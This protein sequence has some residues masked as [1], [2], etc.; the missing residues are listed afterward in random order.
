MHLPLRYL[1]QV[2][3]SIARLGIINALAFLL[4]MMAIL[5]WSC[6]LPYLRDQSRQQQASIIDV[7]KSL[8]TPVKPVFSAPQL[9]EH[10]HLKE[11]YEILGETNYAEQQVKTLFSM[12][13]ENGLLLAQ[14]DYLL[15]SDKAGGFD[16]YQ[17]NFPVK[18]SYSSV[19]QFCMKL[20]PSLPFASLD[21][22]HFKRSVIASD[23]VEVRL[24]LTLYLNNGFSR[25]DRHF[26]PPSHVDADS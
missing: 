15:S 20:L 25:M 19:R 3:L 9:D 13:S 10:D 14:A 2:R 24:Q 17:V 8:Q 4:W 21:E 5:A 26:L 23:V 11:F 18:G 7:R 12:A 1:L 22:L 16:T 6:G